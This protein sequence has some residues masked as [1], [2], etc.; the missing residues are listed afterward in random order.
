MG[1]GVSTV[2]D[3]GRY[4]SLSRAT[5]PALS[6]DVSSNVFELDTKLFSLA[7]L[8][9]RIY[10]RGGTT[11]NWSCDFRAVAIPG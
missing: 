5:Y 6:L 3:F 11:G 9:I 1:C 4:R 8:F 10:Y 2:R 7:C